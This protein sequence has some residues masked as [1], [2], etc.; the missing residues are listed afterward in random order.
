MKNKI[1]YLIGV[2]MLVFAMS[3]VSTGLL[4]AAPQRCD[5]AQQEQTDLSGTYSGRVTYPDGNLSG[6]ATLTIT[7]N[8]FTLESSGST[9]SGRITAVTTCNYTAATLMIGESTPTQMPTII[10]VRARKTGNRLTL[11][12]VAGESHSF[13]FG[14]GTRR[15]VRAPRPA[16]TPAEAMPTNM[17]MGEA[18]PSPTPL[19]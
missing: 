6:D 16:A 7:G 10:S 9:L 17:N 3:M 12:S 1:G 8:Q 5:P 18:T 14:L 4:T 19:N 15:R 13:S 2:G 11:T